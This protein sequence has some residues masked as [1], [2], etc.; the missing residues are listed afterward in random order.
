MKTL[1][2]QYQQFEKDNEHTLAAKLLVDN[3]GTEDE[4]FIMNGIYERH[5]KSSHGISFEDR[6]KRYEISNKY[7]KL[8]L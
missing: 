6:E 5:E 4:K 3:F 2:K 1:L 8:L 7:Y